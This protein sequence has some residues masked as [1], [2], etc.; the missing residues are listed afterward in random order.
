[1]DSTWMINCNNTRGDNLSFTRE[2]QEQ[3]ELTK[4]E[5]R[6]DKMELLKK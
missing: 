3:I 2:Q 6:L 5:Q 1:M 4:L